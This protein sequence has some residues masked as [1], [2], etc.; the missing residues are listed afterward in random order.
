MGKADELNIK[1]KIVAIV[2]IK[3]VFINPI[4]IPNKLAINC[5]I[6]TGQEALRDS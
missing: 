6:T 1:N 2:T 4:Q 3:V 5:N